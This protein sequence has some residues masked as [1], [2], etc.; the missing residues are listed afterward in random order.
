MT[1]MTPYNKFTGQAKMNKIDKNMEDKYKVIIEIPKGR[2]II[3]TNT[4]KNRESL[5]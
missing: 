2:L 4:M 1:K 5:N 3:S